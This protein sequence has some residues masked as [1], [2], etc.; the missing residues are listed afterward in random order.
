MNT[1][2]SSVLLVMQSQSEQNVFSNPVELI[3]QKLDAVVRLLNEMR[4]VEAPKKKQLI[5]RAELCKHLKV[6][7]PTIIRWERNKKIRAIRLG[8]SIRYDL[9]DV[10]EHLKRSA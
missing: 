5:N 3:L 8:R 2:F 7:E 10:I 6:S 9:D 1:V 4:D